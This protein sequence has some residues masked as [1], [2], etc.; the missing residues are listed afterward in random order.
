MK[1]FFVIMFVVLTGSVLL[2]AAGVPES[3]T[4]KE[5]T[6]I[7]WAYWGSGERVTISQQAI[8]L[9]ESRNP[10]VKIN[11]EVSGGAG[12]HFVKVDTQLAGGNGPDIIQMGGNIYER[13]MCCFL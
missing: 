9:Y 11:P 2:F 6:V 10:G 4:Q 7:R 12:D 3:A 1:K 13:Q 8:E 5:D